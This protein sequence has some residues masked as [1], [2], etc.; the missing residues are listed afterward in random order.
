MRKILY[1]EDGRMTKKKRDILFRNRPLD[2]WMVK[3]N[4]RVFFF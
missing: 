2:R 4:G 1:L 3:K